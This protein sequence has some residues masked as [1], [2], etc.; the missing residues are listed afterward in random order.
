M[1]DLVL[2]IVKLIYIDL[3]MAGDVVASEA[4]DAH[5]LQDPGRHGLVYPELLHRLHEPPVQL[6]RPVHL[7]HISTNPSSIHILL[8]TTSTN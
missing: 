7:Q 8:K 4:L 2:D 1:Y 5:E 6:R 3:E